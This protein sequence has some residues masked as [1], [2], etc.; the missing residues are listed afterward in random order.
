MTYAPVR[1]HEKGPVRG[2]APKKKN[3]CSLSLSTSLAADL[4]ALEQHRAALSVSHQGTFQQ[5]A[6]AAA[7][8]AIADQRQLAPAQLLTAWVGA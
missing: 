2:R 5:L 8:R 3:L 1:G 4:S 6:L 7:I